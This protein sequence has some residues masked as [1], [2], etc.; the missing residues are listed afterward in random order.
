MNNR[1]EVQN[2]IEGLENELR[3]KMDTNS[4]KNKQ[5]ELNALKDKLKTL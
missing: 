4:K 1:I 2:A 3:L 5:F